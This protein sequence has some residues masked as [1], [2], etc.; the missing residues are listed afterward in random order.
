MILVGILFAAIARV[1]VHRQAGQ[2][3]GSRLR[4]ERRIDEGMIESLAYRADGR[5]LV[6]GS[7]DGVVRII[8]SRTGD[9]R[10]RVS[11]G[12]GRL[13]SV[14]YRPDG[15]RFAVALEDGSVEV[16]DPD[17]LRPLLSW[18]AHA[19]FASA[20]AYSPDGGRIASASDDRTVRIWDAA[21]GRPLMTLAGHGSTVWSVAYSPD[22]GRVASASDDRTVRIWDAA[23]GR[24]LMTLA[25]T[26]L[27]ASVVYSH[28]GRYLAAGWGDGTAKVYDATSGRLEKTLV[29]RPASQINGVAFDPNKGGRLAT[30]SAN[31]YRGDPP[32]AIR[33]WDLAEGRPTFEFP[34]PRGWAMCVAFDPEGSAVACGGRDGA[35]YVWDVRPTADVSRPSC[36][37]CACRLAIM[38]P[39]SRGPVRR[40]IRQGSGGREIGPVIRRW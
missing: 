22:G 34:L 14:A 19:G 9:V 40:T 16:Y 37:R 13:R 2:V 38:K 29:H 18:K 33:V 30:A 20:V 24:P 7:S 21:D 31:A 1:Q 32:G 26:H 25:G 3:D 36:L 27:A 35:I 10:L 5:C 17:G 28:D 39:G 4:L 23:D 11:P 8:D 12:H 15:R 6:V